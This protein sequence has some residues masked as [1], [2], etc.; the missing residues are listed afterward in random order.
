MNSMIKVFQYLRRQPK[1]TSFINGLFVTAFLKGN[2]LISRHNS[3]IAKYVFSDEA[4]LKQVDDFLAILLSNEKEFSLEVLINLFEFVV[5]PAD[6][7]VDGA[8]YTPKYIRKTIIDKCF[9]KVTNCSRNTRIADIACGCGGFLMDAAQKLHQLTKLPYKVIL[10]ECFFGIDI[11]SYSIERTKILLSMAAL[12]DGE[13]ADFDFKLF[14]HNALDFDFKDTLDSFS[15]FDMIVGNPPY[16]CSRYIPQPIKD[17]MKRWSV[18]SVGHP[19][20][21]IPFFQVAFENLKHGGVLGYIT[22]NSF[23]KSLNGKALRYYFQ[24]TKPLIEILDFR[25]KQI[26][27][28]RSTYTCLFFLKKEKSNCMLYSVNAEPEYLPNKQKTEIDYQSLD[29]VKGWTLNRHHEVLP[30]EQNG[31]PIK[32]YCQTR[33]GIATLSNKTYV[34]MPSS[35]D[36]R[37]Y[38]LQ[39]GNDVF[40]IERDICRSIVNSNKLNGEVS[41]SSIVEKVIFPYKPTENGRM[42]IIEEDVFVEKY[43]GTYSYLLG[44]RSVLE[45]RDK[46]Q[47]R[48]YA[49]WYAYGRTQSLI[50]PYYKLFFPKIANHPLHCELI[51]DPFL[52]LYNGMAFVNDEKET[53][54]VLQKVLES[55]LF[56]NYIVT[57]SKPYMSGFYSLNGSN[58]KHFCVPKFSDEEKKELLNF[59]EKS[60]IE[61]FLEDYYK[62]V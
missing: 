62:Q 48:D 8:V 24:E 34:F 6:K 13:D 21:Y 52:M 7:K 39:K 27:K 25:G 47:T 49:S 16:V 15:G 55:N 44:E 12:V 61:S 9:M 45:K 41:F 51:G 36:E 33:H 29:P 19:D 30:Y 3:V 60:K 37:F 50:L 4:N 20:L 26:F 35:E 5:S 38:Y 56:W 31:I 43:P 17:S 42:S 40:K 18:C 23:L 1:D 58:I 32:D 57:N 2:G 28:K 53:L 11:Q 46:G 59:K 22:V 54:Q 14:T 10:E